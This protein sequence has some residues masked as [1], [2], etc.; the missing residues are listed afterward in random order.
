MRKHPVGAEQVQSFV[1]SVVGDDMH[2]K[3]VLSVANATLGVMPRR[4]R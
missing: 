1:E 2:A 3:R 4:W